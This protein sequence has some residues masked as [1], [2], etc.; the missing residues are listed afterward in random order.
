MGECIDELKKFILEF[1]ITDIVT[2]A[3][4]PG[5]RVKE[6]SLSLELLFLRGSAQIKKRNKLKKTKSNNCI[7]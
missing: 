5:V 3:L 7:N 2:I 1:G 6:M 4:P